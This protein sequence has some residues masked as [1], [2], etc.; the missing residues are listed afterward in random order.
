MLLP[1]DYNTYYIVSGA[2]RSG[3]SLM[4][5]CLEAT[6][7]PVS[8]NPGKDKQLV[9]TAEKGYNPNPYGFYEGG[10]PEIG[11]AVKRIARGLPA[12]ELHG[13]IRLLFMR[14]HKAERKASLSRFGF[15]G[16][17]L[18]SRLETDRPL[19]E[20][21]A[22]HRH[23]LE[24]QDIDYAELLEDPAKVLAR[25]KNSF[26]PVSDPFAAEKCIDWSLYRHRA[27]EL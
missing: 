12:L 19:E 13:P 16:Y 24:R 25:L 21:I 2:H 14:R 5:R 26:W 8:Y 10:K 27:S 6:G 23:G 11:H 7:C 1:E 22:K 4:M 15:S 18:Q 17:Q 3:T 20:F 9:G